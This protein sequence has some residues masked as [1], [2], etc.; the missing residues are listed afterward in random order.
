MGYKKI[1][2]LLMVSILLIVGCDE[3]N[4]N[5]SGNKYDKE[6]Y[7]KIKDFVYVGKQKAPVDAI[8]EVI[9]F[10]SFNNKKD[11]MDY[12]NLWK[13]KYMDVDEEFKQINDLQN[14]NTTISVGMIKKE[15]TFMGS[16]RVVEI[17]PKICFDGKLIN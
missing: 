11:A 17:F 16:E 2:V 13:T 3:I 10:D 14:E 1:V 7:S 9:E 4:V 12:I 15:W 8:F 6:C 5:I